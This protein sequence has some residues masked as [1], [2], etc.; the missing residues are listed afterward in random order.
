M[1]IFKRRRGWAG[2]GAVAVAAVALLSTGGASAQQTPLAANY[3]RSQTLYT[4]GTQYGPPSNWNPMVTGN[5]ATGTIGLLYETLFLYN[6][7]NNQF[8]PWLAK[9]GSFT[10]S[11]VYTLTL[12]PGLAWS[13]G[14]PLTAADVVYTIDLGQYT[15]VP[16]HNIWTYLKS[17]TEVNTTTVSLAFKSTPNYQEWANFL[18]TY[19]ILPKHIWQSRSLTDIITGTNPNPIGSGPYLYLAHDQTTMVWQRN[20]NWWGIKALNLKMAPK[21]I[22]DVANQSN[23]V[24][25]SLLLQDQLDLSNNFLPGIASL[26]GGIG[27]YPIT[28]YYPKAP[29]M[30]SANTAWLVM[31]LKRTPLNDPVFRRALAFAMDIPAVVRSDYNYIV[32]GSNPTGM[33]PTWSQYV[34]QTLVK[35]LG[36]SYNPSK[37]NQMLKSAGYKFG[38]NG[39]VETKSGKPINLSLIVPQ[40]WSDWMAGIQILAQGAA[41]AGIQ[42]TPSFPAYNSLVAQRNSGNFDLVINNDQQISNTPWSYYQWMFGLPILKTQSY[43]NYGRYNNPTAWSLVQQL[44]RTPVTDTAGMKSAIAKLQQIQLSQM[45]VIPLWYNGMWA[46]YNT[47]TWSNWPSSSTYQTV[48]TLWRGYPNMGSVYMLAKIK[49]V[50]AG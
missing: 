5:Y 40:G 39:M 1:S 12:R 37:A 29:Y 2:V 16:Y 32:K 17:V 30:L 28:T 25:L 38:S 14:Q 13:D 20:P 45:P 26:V 15:A 35:S 42:I 24:A 48:P 46:Q 49:P 8:T 11:T 41:K 19:P 33:L 22:V 31:N 9:S 18:Y 44:D 36:F 4:S 27:G 23:N 47:T 3:P 34:D 7:L 43:R 10:S 50:K 21:Y 6:P